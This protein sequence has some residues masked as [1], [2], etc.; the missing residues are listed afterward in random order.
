MRNR[1]L[2]DQ[3]QNSFN[4]QRGGFV[5]PSGQTSPGSQQL[6][7]H[8]SWR[9]QMKWWTDCY[10]QLF[11]GFKISQLWVTHQ[12]MS[13]TPLPISRNS[14]YIDIWDLDSIG[15]KLVDQN[16]PPIYRLILSKSVDL[17]KKRTAEL[18][19]CCPVK[20]QLLTMQTMSAMPCRHTVKQKWTGRRC[21]LQHQHMLPAPFFQ[22]ER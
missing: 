2:S 13:S 3:N 20:K 18:S 5:C 7:S 17:A 8:S 14:L 21:R 10:D 15:G 1:I 9:L 11:S 19:A 4:V 16:R 12:C 6:S 22:A